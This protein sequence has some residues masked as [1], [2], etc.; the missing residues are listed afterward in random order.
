MAAGTIPSSPP[1]VK[2]WQRSAA[3][4]F[5]SR[6]SLGAEPLD[7]SETTLGS[8][9]VAPTPKGPPSVQ[10]LRSRDALTDAPRGRADR[11]LA[12]RGGYVARRRM[13]RVEGR[14][15][16]GVARR[17]GR[18]RSEEQHDDGGV[19]ELVASE[20]REACWCHR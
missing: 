8:P 15:V 10:V 12:Q 18:A 13:T 6:I 1:D 17:A 5:L 20:V 4:R 7:P 3:L 19:V 9:P 2:A 14:G 11:R 16:E